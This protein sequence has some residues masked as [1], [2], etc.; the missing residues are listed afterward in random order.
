MGGLFCKSWHFAFLQHIQFVL[1]SISSTMV[2]HTLT[3]F[4]SSIV[5][6]IVKWFPS[7][8]SF[9]FFWAFQSAM[10]GVARVS[11]SN[12]KSFFYFLWLG[13]FSFCVL[14]DYILCCDY[15]KK[16]FFLMFDRDQKEI[17]DFV[18]SYKPQNNQVGNLRI[19]LHG[20]VGVGKSTFIN[21]VESAVRGRI[22][23]RSLT[24]AT[25]GTSFTQKVNV[26][27]W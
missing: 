13:S 6:R 5:L 11:M 7:M 1:I 10:E 12:R 18:K 9:S 15:V 14:A 19:L 17:L 24:D 20:P 25:S 26:L 22:C 23:G 27:K 3:H 8:F 16:L 21:S 2:W 4:K